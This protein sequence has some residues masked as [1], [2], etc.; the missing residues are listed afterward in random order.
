[1]LKVSNSD[2]R[3][4]LVSRHVRGFTKVGNF[5]TEEQTLNDGSERNFVKEG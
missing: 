2:M 4:V 5:V 1:M 3:V